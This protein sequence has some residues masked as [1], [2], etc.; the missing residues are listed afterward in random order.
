MEELLTY[1]QDHQEID[2]EHLARVEWSFLPLARRRGFTPRALHAEL[3]RNASF[4]AEVISAVYK[5]KSEQGDPNWTPDPAKQNLMT[6][7]HNLLDSW[8]SIPGCTPEG[9]VDS[10][11]LAKWV[12]EARQACS[13]ADRL[14]VCD[15]KIG[16][17]LSVGTSESE[18]DWPCEAVRQVIES[19][20]TDEIIR[21]FDSSV[22]NQRGV[23]TKSLSE[24]GEQE[25]DLAAKYLKLAELFKFRWPRTSL[26]L[27]RIAEGYES[28]AKR[29]DDM[30]E[31]RI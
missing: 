8:N 5:S 20:Q 16:R 13:E 15:L 12:T 19:V 14:E 2:W 11:T 17:L 3:S 24:G 4:F 26:A 29:A 25:R 9:E 31:G 28:D 30:T 7:A 10:A 21:G 6:E 1:A 22:R 27:R 23:Y 18:G